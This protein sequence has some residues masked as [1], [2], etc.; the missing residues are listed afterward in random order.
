MDV[1]DF[2]HAEEDAAEERRSGTISSTELADI[3]ISLRNLLTA[4]GDSNDSSTVA[5]ATITNFIGKGARQARS[6]EEGGRFVRL[7]WT[8]VADMSAPW[9]GG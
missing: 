1:V 7:C 5:A 9:A 8:K 4:A 3:F 2:S 6:Y